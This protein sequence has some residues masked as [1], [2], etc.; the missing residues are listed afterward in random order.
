M[1]LVNW[2]FLILGTICLLSSC[3]FDKALRGPTLEEQA[4]A[5]YG[6]IPS[7]YKE[8]VKGDFYQS[9]IDPYSAKY[10]FC[11]PYKAWASYYRPQPHVLY[12][13][14]ICGTINAK[15]RLGGYVGRKLFWAFFHKGKL[16]EIKQEY[17]AIDPC[18]GN[19]KN[20]LTD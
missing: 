16:V 8:L 5:D 4:K 13:R 1:K 12:G 18:A 6:E 3:A 10:E 11:E 7:N 20:C 19:R 2:L 17:P 15:N 14:G 9:L